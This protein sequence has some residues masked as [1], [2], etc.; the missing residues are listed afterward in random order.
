MKS[1]IGFLVGLGVLLVAFAKVVTNSVEIAK[2]FPDAAHFATVVLEAIGWEP[3]IKVIKGSSMKVQYNAGFSVTPCAYEPDPD[4]KLVEGE[5]KM[6][7]VFG[8]VDPPTPNTPNPVFLNATYTQVCG[9]FV[10]KGSMGGGDSYADVY[11][12]GYSIKR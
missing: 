8:H 1:A 7:N 9:T 5:P 4:R 3:K 10:A 11:I 2:Q 6:E 12:V